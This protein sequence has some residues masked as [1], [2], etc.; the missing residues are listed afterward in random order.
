MTSDILRAARA[1]AADKEWK[2]I[3]NLTVITGAAY[4]KW[5]RCGNLESWCDAVIKDKGRLASNDG[6]VVKDERTKAW[7]AVP[8]EQF[9]GP[10]AD[11]RAVLK[12][13]KNDTGLSAE[14]RARVTGLDTM[15]KLLI[16]TLFGDL[17]SRFFPIN[18]VVVANNI[19][20]RGRVGVWMLAKALRLR[21][22]ITDGG[23]FEPWRV[24]MWKGPTP[25]LAALADMHDWRDKEHGRRFYV[26]LG[27]ADW[28]QLIALSQSTAARPEEEIKQHWKAQLPDLDT[29]ALEHVKR[30]W[31]PYGL[32]FPFK[33]IAH[34]LENT[35]SVAGYWAKGDYALR[36]AVPLL[37]KKGNEQP[38]R[39]AVRGKDRTKRKDYV[40]PHPTFQV[41][42]NILDGKDE[43]PSDLTY[44]KTG[45]VTVNEYHQYQRTNRS[46]EWK[47]LRPGD[48]KPVVE[49]T[50]SY[51]NTHMPIA[52]I[53]EYN[54]RAHERK[55]VRDGKPVPLFER[56]APGGIKLL[57][58][59]MVKDKLRTKYGERN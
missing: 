50:A 9:I 14:E 7:L 2:E 35:F 48:R 40:K 27:D 47:A 57:H 52:N 38:K 30:F 3:K 24:P 29:L 36:R 16:N 28:K 26:S 37:D 55:K 41:L 42:D 31:S 10:L 15:F 53:R 8:L 21:Q 43:F 39:Y 58:N 12:A 18:N 19:T 44:T 33:K 32:E 46:P 45:L 17:A 1:A 51:N 5:D 13:K 59:H 34:K 11:E 49:L 25:G 54:R 6:K 23:I 56:F 22:S 20:G 4:L